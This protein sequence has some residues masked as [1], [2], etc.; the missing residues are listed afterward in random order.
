VKY[1]YPT[2]LMLF[3]S[4]NLLSQEQG[5]DSLADRKAIVFSLSSLNLSGGIGG[6]YWISSNTAIRGHVTIFYENSTKNDLLFLNPP[7]RSTEVTT[8]QITPSIYLMRYLYSNGSLAPY[9]GANIGVERD[10]KEY[11]YDYKDSTECYSSVEYHY[12]GGVF[13][14]LEY[15]VSKNIS[16]SAEQ[17]ISFR[18]SKEYYSKD[19]EMFNSTSLLT[20][21]VYL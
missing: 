19:F 4:Q 2:I 20:L 18:Y 11:H 6:K 12:F 15:W 3:V 5:N 17:S 10:F 9:F 7:T 1:F 16:F 13:V 21:S 14:G 8:F